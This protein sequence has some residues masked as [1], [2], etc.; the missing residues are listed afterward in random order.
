MVS[1]EAIMEGG[2]LRVLVDEL[3]DKYLSEAL[4]EVLEPA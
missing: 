1:C 3:K 2:G 4:E